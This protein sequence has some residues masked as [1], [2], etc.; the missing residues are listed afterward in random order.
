MVAGGGR[1]PPGLGHHRH[2][3]CRFRRRAWLFAA[4]VQTGCR[5][6]P[7]VASLLG[8]IVTMTHAVGDPGPRQIFE[9]VGMPVAVFLVWYSGAARKRGWIT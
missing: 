4:V 5:P 9:A 8:V 3:H 7:F 2:G 6:L 1:K